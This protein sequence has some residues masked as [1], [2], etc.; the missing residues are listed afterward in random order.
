MMASLG[1][2]FVPAPLPGDA[3]NW[4]TSS[5]PMGMAAVAGALSIGSIINTNILPLNRILT[6]AVIFCDE[7]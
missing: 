3:A 5:R 7:I 6:A 2:L 4:T 1:S